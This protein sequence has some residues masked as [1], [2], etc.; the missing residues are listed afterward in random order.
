[1]DT[2]IEYAHMADREVLVEVGSRKEYEHALGTEADLV[3]IN[4]RDLRTFAVDLERTRVIP[5]GL[6][7]SKPLVSLSGYETRAQIERYTPFADAFLVGS[8]LVD[9]RAALK[10]LVGA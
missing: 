5:E 4:N 9:G 6:E 7:R 3:G 8:S 10:E 2:L 1:M